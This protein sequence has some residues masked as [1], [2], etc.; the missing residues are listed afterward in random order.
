MPT[1]HVSVALMIRLLW[2]DLALALPF[3]AALTSALQCRLA[4][5]LAGSGLTSTVVH[6]RV[7]VVGVGRALTRLDRSLL[8]AWLIEQ[9][10]VA[11]VSFARPGVSGKVVL[12]EIDRHA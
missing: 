8:I 2:L 3:D 7:L 11:R 5:Y 12:M 1:V 6:G 4:N 9:P 10:E